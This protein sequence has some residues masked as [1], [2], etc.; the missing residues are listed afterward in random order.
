[1]ERF[2][3]E[4]IKIIELGTHVAVPSGTRFLADFG[5]EVIKIEGLTGDAYRAFGASDGLPVEPDYNPM[6]TQWNANKKLISLNLKSEEGKEAFF[7]LLEDADVLV[8]NVRGAGLRKMGLDYDSLKDRFPRLVYYHFTG[9][10]QTGPDAARPGFDVAAF[11]ARSGLLLDAVHKGSL[12]V[13]PPKAMGDCSSGASVAVG[14][15]IA[16][17]GRDLT[18]HGTFVTSSLYGTGAYYAGN[19]VLTAQEK[20]GVEYPMDISASLNPLRNYYQCSDGGWIVI[21]AQDYDKDWKKYARVFGLDEFSDNEEYA[22]LKNIRVYNHVPEIYQKVKEKF[23]TMT[24]PEWCELLLKEDIVHE[25]MRHLKDVSTDEQ[26]IA[27][28]YVDTVKFDNGEEVILPTSPVQMSAFPKK[29]LKA[30]P[31]I[32]ADTMEV[33]KGLGYSEEQIKELEAAGVL[34]C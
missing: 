18:G 22:T 9:L 20:F 3:L 29:K 7:K 8:S 5:A 30:S 25:R 2:P 6:F 13:K 33:L 4:G 19:G 23:A 10:G 1:M 34:K 15:L 27:N 21:W 14:I 24:T 26:A 28:G 32:G 16:L 17:R 31:H 11:W 12:P